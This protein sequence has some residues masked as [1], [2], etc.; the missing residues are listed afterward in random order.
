M[1]KSIRRVALLTAALMALS[2]AAA[3][4]ELSFAGH[5]VAETTDT[6]NAPFGGLVDSVDVRAGDTVGIGDPVATLET[7]KVYATADGV[8]GGV[9]AEPGDDTEG[10]VERYGAVVYIEPTNRYTVSATTEKAYNSSETK[11]VHIGERVYLSCTKDGTHTGT[12]VVTSIG[13]SASSGGDSGDGGGS[14]GSSGGI[15]SYTLEITGGEFYMGETVG[16][17]RSRDYDSS[18]RIGRGTVEQNAAIAVKGSGSVLKMHVSVGDPVER[19]ELLFETVTGTLDGLYAVDNRIVSNVAGVVASVD[20][21]PGTSVEKGAK[22]I[23]IDPQFTASAAHS[24]TYV[25]ITPGTDGAMMLAMANYII[26]N[27]LMDVA[28]M[29]SSTVSPFLVKEDG[30]YLRLSDFGVAPTEGPVNPQTGQPTKIDPVMVWDEATGDKAP[31]PKAA[32]PAV[33]GSFEIEGVTYKTVF[34]TVKDSIKDY[35]LAKASGICG[36]PESTIEE[37]ARIYA[38]EGPV[39]VMTFQGLGHHAN[40]HHNY[41]NLAFLAALTGNAGKPGAAICGNPAPSSMVPYNTKAFMAG[42]PGP[43]ICGM[44][45]PEIVANKKF[46]Q[47]DIDLQVLWIHN[48]NVLSCESGRQELIEA[49][50]KIDFVVCADVNMNDSAQWADIVLPVPHAF[51]MEDIDP[52]GSTPFPAYYEKGLEPLYECK[53][54]VE[55]MRLLSQKM[56]MEK[57]YAKS[58]QDFLRDVYNTDT[59]KKAGVSYDDFASGEFVR[60]PMTK[61]E[62]LVPTYGPAEG[63]RLKYY[64]EK[65]TPRNSFGQEIADY[66]KLPYYEH[67]NEAYLDNPLREKY[68]L[69]GCSEHNKYHVHS[70]LAVTPVIRELEPEPMIKINAADAA[71]RGI[72]QGDLVRAYNDHGYAVVKALVTEGIMPGVVSIPHGFQATQY[73]EGHTQDLTNVFMNDFCSNSA[74]YDFLCEVEKC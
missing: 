39:Y 27:N 47:D 53:T 36:V 35:S 15:T 44:Y 38:T 18:S 73:V 8:V 46:G 30:T 20:A 68:P 52:V 48:G 60:N 32:D 59:N 10:I 3:L 43:R 31:L 14:S 56:G 50:K 6:V 17:F 2:G 58:D 40:S 16:I 67:A 7:T 29:K 63:T 74:F 13:G 37:L 51:E 26:E 71:A 42:K 9:F 62:N 25:P 69:L 33:E 57:I 61:P 34:Q 66:E 11:Y 65:P 28:Y 55:I 1:K 4:A 19:G 70:Q 21:A 41:K 49:V 54:D 5:V 64:I 24:D 45:L 23:T 72:K 12:A 22:L